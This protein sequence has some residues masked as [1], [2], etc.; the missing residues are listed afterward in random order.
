MHDKIICGLGSASGNNFKDDY[1]DRPKNEDVPRQK[2]VCFF[3]ESQVR[4]QNGNH[5][6]LLQ[7]SA[8]KFQVQIRKS[9]FLFS[10]ED[11]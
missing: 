11:F 1:T 6:D 5:S 2:L 10:F 8:S 9:R 4:H 3:S 7:A